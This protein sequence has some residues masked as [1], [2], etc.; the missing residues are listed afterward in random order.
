MVAEGTTAG[1]G[2]GKSQ[3]RKTEKIGGDGIVR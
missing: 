3:K 2:D 1:K